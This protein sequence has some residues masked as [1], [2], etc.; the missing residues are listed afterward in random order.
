VSWIFDPAQSAAVGGYG[1]ILS[2]V[3]TLLTLFGLYATYRQA[4]TARRSAEDAEAAVKDFRFRSDRYDSF[5][6]LSQASY[7]LEMTKRHLNNDAWRDASESYEDARRAI[8]RVRLSAP[9]LPDQSRKSL[10]QIASHMAAFCDAVDRAVAD[11][12]DY[13]DTFKVLA[14]IR[15]NYETIAV[16]QRS[17]KEEPRNVSPEGQI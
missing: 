10:G 2:F 7:A 17:L 9:D 15:K 8:I 12:G 16:I 1:L 4:R 3:G 11:K 13:P 14:T 6:D 5:R